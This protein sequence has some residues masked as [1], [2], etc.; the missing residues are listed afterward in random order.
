MRQR[1]LSQL[2]FLGSCT[3]FLDRFDPPVKRVVCVLHVAEQVWAKLF[4]VA[5]FEEM[6][7]ER[8]GLR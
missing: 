5:L 8:Y 2:P 1:A 3:I 4:S 7:I 6:E